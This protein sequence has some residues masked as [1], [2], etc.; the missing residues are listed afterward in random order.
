MKKI[1][2]MKRIME[3]TVGRVVE[4]VVKETVEIDH[5]VVETEFKKVKN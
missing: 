2:V 3:E 1:K 5:K 4:K